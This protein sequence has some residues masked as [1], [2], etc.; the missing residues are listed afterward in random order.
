MMKTE[1][2]ERMK[3]GII[4][5]P[6][7]NTRSIRESSEETALAAALAATAAVSSGAVVVICRSNDVILV[8]KNPE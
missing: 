8:L 5:H 4:T 1:I 7:C 2:K 6:P 3:I